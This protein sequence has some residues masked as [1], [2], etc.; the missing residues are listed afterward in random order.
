T[1]LRIWQVACPQWGF[2]ISNRRA[3]RQG[4]RHAA[5]VY[6]TAA[7][8]ET[9]LKPENLQ[10]QVRPPHPRTSDRQLWREC[11]LSTVCAYTPVDVRQEGRYLV[12]VW[13]WPPPNAPT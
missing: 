2:A 10:L 3:I 13:A 7:G 11:S 6:D 1:A 12:A 8:L 5:E 9:I 4:F